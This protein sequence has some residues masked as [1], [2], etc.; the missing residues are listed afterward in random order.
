MY[1]CRAE[2]LWC[3]PPK[4][5]LTLGPCPWEGTV[6]GVGLGGSECCL[7]PVSGLSFSPQWS[8]VSVPA[9]LVCPYQPAGRWCE[10]WMWN[11]FREERAQ[12]RRLRCEWTASSLLRETL[13]L[14]QRQVGSALRELTIKPHFAWA[15]SETTFPETTSPASICTVEGV[16]GYAAPCLGVHL[17]PLIPAP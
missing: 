17:G 14:A 12:G 9:L 6:K 4:L 2:G 16:P 11:F 1:V 7:W 13:D 8:R 5:G 15:G 3:V 10:L